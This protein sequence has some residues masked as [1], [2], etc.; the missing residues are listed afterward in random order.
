MD[1]Q[2]TKSAD[3]NKIEG[4]PSKDLFINMLIKDI[5]LKDAIGD[6]VDNSVDAANKC[7]K[8]KGDLSDFSIHI[9]I[10]KNN[11]E[12]ID[13]A[14]GIEENVARESAFKLGKP[15]SF[16]FGKYTIGQFGIGMK[17][18]FFKLGEHIVV[19]SVA[20]NSS[21]KLKILVP[22]WRDK[23]NEKDWDFTFD[24]VN[25]EKHRLKDT[26]TKINITDLKEDVKKQFAE[27]QFLIDLKNEIALEHLF[28]INKGLTISINTKEKLKAPQINLIYDKDFKPC[29]W[30]YEFKSGLKAE[31]I[32][33]VSEDIGEEG[34]WYIFCNNRLILGPDTTE[35]TGWKGGRGKGGKEG[36]ELPKYHDQFFRFRGYVFFNAVDSSLLPWTT[37]K[38]GMDK[39]SPAFTFVRT[40]MI[41]MGKQVKG[42]MDDMSKERKQGNPPDK[43]ILSQRVENAT[44]VSVTDVMKDKTKLPSVY[45]YPK[46]LLST[47]TKEKITLSFPKSKK[48]V[49]KA[50]DYFN[51]EDANSA[52]SFAFDYFIEN[53]IGKK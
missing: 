9:K 6:L 34:G 41:N 17:R 5:T 30:N 2:Q 8:N 36:K 26:M 18:A 51:V 49:E 33:G 21:F 4:T 13:N 44:V 11:F 27:P 1:A 31:I 19:E 37:S 39:D 40:Q 14:G 23:K 52:G 50:K 10:D 45:K 28:A 47:A 42:L 35:V 3:L 53:A 12:I 7:A 43:R 38:T 20:L 15:K 25:H 46:H 24:S 32:A 16:K 48:E 29:Y 22:E